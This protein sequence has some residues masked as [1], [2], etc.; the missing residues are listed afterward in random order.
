MKTVAMLLGVFGGVL[1][2]PAAFIGMLTLGAISGFAVGFAAMITPIVG[3]VGAGF[4]QKKPLISAALM[5]IAG[6][7]MFVAGLGIFGIPSALC[8]LVAALLE[9]IGKTMP[10]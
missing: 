3:L 8:F 1:G 2:L 9:V 5:G 7:G 6:A 4:S 10:S